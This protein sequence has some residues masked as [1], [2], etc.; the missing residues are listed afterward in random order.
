[1]SVRHTISCIVVD[2]TNM[3]LSQADAQVSQWKTSRVVS[4]MNICQTLVACYGTL[5][6]SASHT[7]EPALHKVFTVHTP[8]VC[9]PKAD[10]DGIYFEMV[11]RLF[12]FLGEVSYR[13]GV[14]N[15]ARNILQSTLIHATA[16]CMDALATNQAVAKRLRLAI[17][18]RHKENQYSQLVPAL[19]VLCQIHGLALARKCLLNGL[20]HFWSSVVRLGHLFEVGSFRMQFKRALITIIHRSYKY[21]A[22]PQ[23]PAGSKEWHDRR[24][25]W[26]GLSSEP[27]PAHTHAKKRKE[28]HRA[29][30]VFDNADHESSDII[31][32]CDGSC[33]HGSD[34]KT[35]SRYAL[36]Q[37]L[38]HYIAL[39]GCG[40][41]TPLTY[42]WI[43]AARSL[44]YLKDPCIDLA[45]GLKTREQ[46]K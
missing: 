20:P 29:L 3:R 40:Y 41:P 18:S 26:C 25:Q 15:L 4:V 39:F 42:R 9:L 16:L 7:L 43:H 1:M 37:I 34:H 22:V 8:M 30:M 10:V 14:L 44:Q 13:F 11:S 17:H 36:V 24:R 12:V 32:F 33:C 31:H 19:I 2:D 35:K 45:I 6:S 23:M 27:L 5:V 38:Q 46:T 28:L 21:I